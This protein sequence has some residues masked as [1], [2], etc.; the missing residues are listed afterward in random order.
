M[1]PTV[2]QGMYN[3]ITRSV[4]RELFPALRSCGMRFYAYNPMAGGLLSGKYKSMDDSREEGSRFSDSF[5]ITGQYGG[6][7]PT[8]GKP[9]QSQGRYWKREMF[10][11]LDV[12]HTA[13]E[14]EGTPMAEAALRWMVHHSALSAKH[15]D[16]IVMG[17]SQLRHLE[18]NL[19]AIQQPRLSEALVNAFDAA[20]KVAYAEA[21]LYFRGYGPSAGDSSKFLGQFL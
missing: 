4:E 1:R 7:K 3:S 6:G 18:A 13:C 17:A 5:R 14:A 11:A 12:L 10:A 9:T 21:E 19:A 8:G 2:Y 15:G 20:N 16:G